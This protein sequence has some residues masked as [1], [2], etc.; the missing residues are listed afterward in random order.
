[1]TN[2]LVEEFYKEKEALENARRYVNVVM[3]KM[4]YDR[5]GDYIKVYVEKDKYIDISAEIAKD[6]LA[7]VYKELNNLSFYP[8]IKETIEGNMRD[9]RR[10]IGDDF[11][12]KGG[13]QK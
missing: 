8:L 10:K 7:R 13:V 11:G 2:N 4:V 5:N 6:V 12:I 1:M 3:K 9:L